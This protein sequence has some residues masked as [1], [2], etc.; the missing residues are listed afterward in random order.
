MSVKLKAANTNYEGTIAGT[1]FRKGLGTFEDEKLGKRIAAE[2]GLEVV[3]AAAKKAE[4]PKVEEPEVEEPKA[5]APK[6]AA[7]KRK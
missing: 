6:A 2:F 5:A 4:E 1:R 3:K 7:R